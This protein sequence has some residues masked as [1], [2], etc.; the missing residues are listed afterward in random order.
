MD[1]KAFSVMLCFRHSNTS[2]GMPMFPS[3]SSSEGNV[4]LQRLPQ[5]RAKA[6]FSC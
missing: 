2:P 5:H 4:L 3:S 6:N 1:L